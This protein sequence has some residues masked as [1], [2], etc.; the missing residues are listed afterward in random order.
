VRAL[1]MGSMLTA[2]VVSSGATGGLPMR[3]WLIA[4]APQRTGQKVRHIC[5][6][7]QT[8]ENCTN[9]VRFCHNGQLRGATTEPDMYFVQ[10]TTRT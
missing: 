4:T 3:S 10:P 7:L 8:R 9:T 2:P 6:Q 5:E 1:I